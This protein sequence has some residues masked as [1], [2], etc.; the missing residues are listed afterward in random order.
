MNGLY[1]LI[2]VSG[3]LG[4]FL[5]G[6]VIM[7]DAL[8]GLAG[9]S[10]RNAL[11]RFTR[12]PVS[13]AIT[14]AIGTAI[15]QSSSA[16]TVAAVGFVS[17]GLLSFTQALG[18]IF[19]ANI[20]T[21][22]TGW[23]V[24]LLGFK[25]DLNTLLLPLILMGVLL[26]ISQ[27]QG[28]RHIGM[29]LAG[30]GLIFVG[31]AT[32][33]GALGDLDKSL[34]PNL[35][36]EDNWSTR[37]QL[38]ALGM[39]VT[40]ITQSSSAG[41]ATAIT[42]LYVGAISFHQAAALVV[43]MDVGTT[44]TA[45]LASIGGTQ[46]SRRTGLSHVIYNCFTAI[47]ALLLITPF[48][49]LWLW[50]ADGAA[51]SQHAEIALVAFHTSFNTLGVLIVLP[52][53]AQFARLMYRLVPE[54]T[55]PYTHSLD[56]SQIQASDLAV[57]ASRVAITSQFEAMLNYVVRLLGSRSY[58]NINIIVDLLAALN[59]TEDFLDKVHIK[60]EQQNDW[61]RL[62]AIFHAVDH[63]GRLLHRCQEAEKAQLL[64]DYAPLTV[65][66]QGSTNT[67]N[68]ILEA[69]QQGNWN[70]AVNLA[71]QQ[72]NL[73]EQQTQPLRA[74]IM[75]SMASGELGFEAADD[76]LDAL[77]WQ[78]RVFNHIARITHYLEQAQ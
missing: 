58:H 73:I 57:T 34:M 27:R 71:N 56:P 54:T 65:L 69:T 49:Q 51:I 68:A 59:T 8:R 43:G 24:A 22:I 37:L 36:P 16:T 76:Y 46:A 6:M 67:I 18:I 15:L 66:I 21:T 13:G 48:T 20:G 77:R 23:L 26:R 5:L 78:G 3:G 50:F 11:M 28:L 31:I 17:A 4:L 32:L 64:S 25:L 42:A 60:T 72:L 40:I 10:I 7:T 14:G 35:F 74:T 70:V 33:Q 53:A 2:E 19:G 63:L 12:T 45:A 44:V 52:F 9:R 61:Q 38:F 75:G 30:F 47:G 29:A 41:V 1:I 55:N 39:L 62:S